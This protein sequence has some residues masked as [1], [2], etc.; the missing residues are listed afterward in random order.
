MCLQEDALHEEDYRFQ[1][2][3]RHPA[4]KKNMDLFLANGGQTRAGELDL[5]GTMRRAGMIAKI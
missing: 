4:A 2:T 5:Q 1:E 3:L